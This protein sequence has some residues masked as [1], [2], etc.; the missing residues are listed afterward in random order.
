MRQRIAVTMVAV[1]LLMAACGDS[2]DSADSGDG[3]VTVETLTPLAPDNSTPEPAGGTRP[4]GGEDIFAIADLTVTV[5][6]PE[7]DTVS[8]R[9]S[10]LG[11]TAT[12][13]DAPLGVDPELA[14]TA[15]GDAGVVERLVEGPP[16]DQMCTENYGG[17][18]VATITG[19]LDGAS[20]EAT[21][22]RTNG[23]G[24]S[25][26]EQ[27]LADILPAAVGVTS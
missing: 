22:N 27:L 10:C 12:I 8:Y 6:H 3:G 4:A 23:C 25:D 11:D 24:I 18:D 7:R 5:I 17:P 21:V 26:W 20:V 14:C 2:D 16:A 13:E 15:L 19:T 1:G 9:I